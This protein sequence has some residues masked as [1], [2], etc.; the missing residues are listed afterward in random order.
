MPSGD[1]Q[2]TC[3]PEMIVR[4]RSEWYQGMSMPALISLRDELD[5]M[6][7][8]IRTGRNIQAPIVTCRRCGTTGPAA[9][10]QVS[11]RALILAVARFGIASEGSNPPA[12]KCVGRIPQTTPARRRR[13]SALTCS[14]KL[15]ALTIPS[16]VGPSA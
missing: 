15:P 12:G 6:L 5:G 8:R 7:Q 11:V 4:L 1:A 2:R 10:P 13:K 16:E 14:A 3:F 9:E